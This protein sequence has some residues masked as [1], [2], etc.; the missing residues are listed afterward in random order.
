MDNVLLSGPA[1]HALNF[2]SIISRS[3][4]LLISFL[5]FPGPAALPEYLH[6]EAVTESCFGHPV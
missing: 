2:T 1:R 5:D 6:V 4:F 3:P